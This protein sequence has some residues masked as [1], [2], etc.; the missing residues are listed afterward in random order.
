[1]ASY[2]FIILLAQIV[3]LALEILILFRLSQLVG[4]QTGKKAKK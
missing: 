4:Q 2:E 3:T 1:M